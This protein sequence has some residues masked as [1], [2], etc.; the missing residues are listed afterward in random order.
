VALTAAQWNSLV[1]LRPSDFKKPEGLQFSIVSALDRFI[2]KIGSRPVILSDY[3]PDD[4]RTH[5][6]G[7][8]IDTTW[9]G[10][11]PVTVYGKALSFSDFGGVGIYVN[12]LGVASFHFDTRQD[13]IRTDEPD[14]WG[15]IIT[16]P[17][18]ATTGEHVRRTEYVAAN[19][20]LDILKKK[21]FLPIIGL[22][23]L[24]LAIYLFTSQ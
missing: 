6:Q 16:H 8:A 7:I 17:L 5:G 4:P 11:S 19:I 20:V 12:E 3:R 10:A 23:V 18:D 14:R 15:G 9:P 24:G 22:I 1:Y 13:T 21:G 2:G